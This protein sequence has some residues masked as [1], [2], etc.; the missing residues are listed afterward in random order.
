MPDLPAP[1]SL[2][3]EQYDLVVDVFTRSAQAMGLSGPVEAYNRWFV[4]NLISL[5][6]RDADATLTAEFDERRAEQR[7]ILDGIISGT[8]P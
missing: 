1:P 4:D 3:Q 2:N 6:R 8:Q 7:A 5:V